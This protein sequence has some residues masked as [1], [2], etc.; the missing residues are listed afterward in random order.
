MVRSE[1]RAATQNGLCCLLCSTAF[2]LTL[3]GVNS[4]VLLCSLMHHHVLGLTDCQPPIR[5]R[6]HPHALAGFDKSS[7]SDATIDEQ[8]MPPQASR[9]SQGAIVFAVGLTLIC[10]TP[11]L[12]GAA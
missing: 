2:T 8:P 6:L 5:Q 9:D 11:G 7:L 1:H 12:T 4:W 10:A 3:T